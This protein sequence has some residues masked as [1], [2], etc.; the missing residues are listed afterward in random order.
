MVS[1]H[2]PFLSFFPSLCFPPLLFCSPC[3]LRSPEVIPP[4][5]S[6]GA[7]KASGEPTSSLLHS[8]SNP[9]LWP[10]NDLFAFGPPLVQ[11]EGSERGWV[12]M[13]AGRLLQTRGKVTQPDAASGSCASADCRRKS[14]AGLELS[15]PER[16]ALRKG[17]RLTSTSA[18]ADT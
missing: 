5:N 8:R 4:F 14:K 10:R 15:N 17:R 6:H 7:P 16:E 2:F 12:Q 3:S 18:G 13:V 11:K 9:T 1:P